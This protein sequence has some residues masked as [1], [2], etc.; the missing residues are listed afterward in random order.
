MLLQNN[1]SAAITVPTIM[2][3]ITL[4]VKKCEHAEANPLV[5]AVNKKMKQIMDRNRC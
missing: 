3:V 1:N 2:A 5:L 4:M